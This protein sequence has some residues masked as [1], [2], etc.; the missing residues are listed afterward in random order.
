VEKAMKEINKN[1]KE[2][3]FWEKDWEER[4]NETEICLYSKRCLKI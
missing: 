2:I 3:F 4:R 1:V